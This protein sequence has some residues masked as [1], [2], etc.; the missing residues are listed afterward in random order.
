LF[1]DGFLELDDEYFFFSETP[2]DFL[3]VFDL[4][5][6]CP[7]ELLFL[8]EEVLIGGDHIEN[9]VDGAHVEFVEV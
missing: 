4:V 5:F 8:F 9:F 2:I 6:D 7:T 3:I 1:F